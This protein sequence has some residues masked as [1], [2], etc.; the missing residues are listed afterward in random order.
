[1][2]FGGAKV[3]YFLS[4]PLFSENTWRIIKNLVQIKLILISRRFHPSKNPV[5]HRKH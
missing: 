1:M 5:W 3:I 4:V 2:N